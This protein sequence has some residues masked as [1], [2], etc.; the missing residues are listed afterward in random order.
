[1]KIKLP[2]FYERE[3]VAEIQQPMAWH[4]GGVGDLVPKLYLTLSTS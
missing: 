4:S 3:N 2:Q 1:M